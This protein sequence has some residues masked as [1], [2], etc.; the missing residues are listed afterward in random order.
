M[1]AQTWRPPPGF[2]WYRDPGDDSVWFAEWPLSSARR[3]RLTQRREASA[4]SPAGWYL[5][6]EDRDGNTTRG[7]WMGLRVNDAKRSA[8]KWI[9]ERGERPQL[10]QDS[11]RRQQPG[12]A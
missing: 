2:Q 6:G 9:T 1:T 4:D 12:Q 10:I 11:R 3:W 5:D 8:C 7:L